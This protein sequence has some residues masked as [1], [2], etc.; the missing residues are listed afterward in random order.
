MTA[1]PGLAQDALYP[2]YGD[3]GRQ[4]VN[5]VETMSVMFNRVLS[6]KY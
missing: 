6:F 5:A 4:T 2:Y 1:E 3:S